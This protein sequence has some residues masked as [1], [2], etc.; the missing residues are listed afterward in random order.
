MGKQSHKYKSDKLGMS[1]GKANA[2]LRKSI[3]FD[4]V[5]KS[6]LGKCFKCNLPIN[7]EDELTIEHK[8]NWLN[9][10]NPVK[11]FFDLNNIAFSHKRCNKCSPQQSTVRSTSGYKG[12]KKC[13]RKNRKG[14]RYWAVYVT[15]N[16][17]CKYVGRFTDPKVAARAY[18]EAVVSILG[19]S[20][21][22]NHKLGL[23]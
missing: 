14:I 7:N 9:S 19:A 5:I 12:V 3:L 8:T 10:D 6:G 22:T 4:L 17:L 23:L 15:S 1:L 20:A 11:L 16:G 18:D 21:I 2:R 13:S